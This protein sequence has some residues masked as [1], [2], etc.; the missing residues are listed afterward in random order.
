MKNEYEKLNL[1]IIEF[2]T[3][4]VITSSDKNFGDPDDVD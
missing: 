4:D 2:E 1:E 3:Q